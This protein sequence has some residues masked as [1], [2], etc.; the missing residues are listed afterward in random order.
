M[1]LGA[2]KVVASVK[3]EAAPALVSLE[4]ERLSASGGV[5]AGGPDGDGFDLHLRYEGAR[6]M[7]L[8]KSDDGRPIFVCEFDAQ[9]VVIVPYCGTLSLVG[10]Q[11]RYRWSIA[12]PEKW[13]G[14][15]VPSWHALTRYL[16]RVTSF[17]VPDGHTR[18]G[19]LNAG[20]IVT[21]ADGDTWALDGNPKPIASG[22]KATTTAPI[23][24]FTLAHF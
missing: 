18:I 2:G 10:G 16:G 14:V 7:L 20:S 15:Y 22:T 3:I 17:T 4:C 11:G 23:R 5:P 24:I 19:S 12:R 21:S 8:E 9:R 6:P 13:N 1:A